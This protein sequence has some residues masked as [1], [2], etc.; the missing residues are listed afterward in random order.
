[1][2]ELTVDI[3]KIINAPI[4]KVFDAWLN[5]KLL[6]KFMMGMPD[7]LETD[8]EIDARKGGHFTFIMHLGDEKIPHTGEYLEINRP[9]KLVFTWVSSHSVVDNSAVTLN[10]TKVGDNKTKISLSHVKFI[11][12]EARSGHER[13]WG[14]VLDKL[15]AIMS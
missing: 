2:T 15:N 7:M 8:V 4:E 5:P 12:E 14:C 1:M 13:G 6:S 9:D 11:D 3:E 10:F